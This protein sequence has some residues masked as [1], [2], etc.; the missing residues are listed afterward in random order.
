MIN[1]NVWSTITTLNVLDTY[2]L[3]QFCKE[4]ELP[5]SFN[6]LNKPKQ[7]N[8]CLFNKKQKKYITDKLLNIQDDEFQKIIEP[9]V[10]LMNSTTTSTDTANMIDFLTTTDKIRNQDYKQTYKELANIL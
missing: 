5:V 6:P 7:L 4:Y 1:L 9:I 10:S 8:I 3:F 2:T